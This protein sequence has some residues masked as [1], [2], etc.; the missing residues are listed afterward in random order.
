MELSVDK[1]REYA[2]KL[3]IPFHAEIF[4]YLFPARYLS[5][6]NSP[7]SFVRLEKGEE[8]PFLPA[9]CHLAV[10]DPESPRSS[11][12]KARRRSEWRNTRNLLSELAAAAGYEPGEFRVKKDEFGKPCGYYRHRTVP[13]SLAHSRDRIA[14]VIS[15][16]GEVGVD[17]EPAGRRVPEGLRDRMLHPDEAGLLEEVDTIR[18]WTLKEA[19]AKL[20][21]RGLRNNMDEMRIT[22][23]EPNLFEA[24][25]N[26]DKRAK[27]CSFQHDNYWMALAHY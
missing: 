21:G 1:N 26:N 7:F 24:N 11:D 25:F 20:E 13:V 2:A 4:P 8:Y 18:I 3:W 19:L 5:V 14:C 9:D 6:M 15:E 10:A 23:R 22:R 27:I 12:R 17:L 16:G